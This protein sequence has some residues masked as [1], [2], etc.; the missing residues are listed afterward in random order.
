MLRND[1]FTFVYFAARKF[2]FCC[3]KQKR[4][5]AVSISYGKYFTE[6]TI[7]VLNNIRY[8]REKLFLL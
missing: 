4:I 2:M 5:P 7:S 6:S 8:V 1:K 3:R